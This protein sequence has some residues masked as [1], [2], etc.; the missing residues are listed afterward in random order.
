MQIHVP[1][2]KCAYEDVAV[3]IVRLK[4]QLLCAEKHVIQTTAAA[5]AAVRVGEYYYFEL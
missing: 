2:T 1:L 5:A 4:P 3:I